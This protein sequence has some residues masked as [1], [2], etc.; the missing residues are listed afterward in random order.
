MSSKSKR[1][2]PNLHTCMDCGKR[3]AVVRVN[4]RVDEEWICIRCQRKRNDT[5]KE[6]VRTSGAPVMQPIDPDG[7]PPMRCSFPIL[8]P[9]PAYKLPA[10]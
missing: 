9:V 3:N 6:L 5:L 1:R 10:H 2:R 8:L 7:G 4:M